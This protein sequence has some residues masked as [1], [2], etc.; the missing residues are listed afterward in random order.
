MLVVSL[1]LFYFYYFNVGW[2][3]KWGLGHSSV[4]FMMFCLQICK[5]SL[6]LFKEK[7]LKVFVG[8]FLLLVA[9]LENEI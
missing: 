3:L 2:R 6:Y 7:V 4:L 9:D 1:T 8:I 5:S